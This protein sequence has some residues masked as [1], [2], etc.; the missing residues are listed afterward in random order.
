MNE[1]TRD[2]SLDPITRSFIQEVDGGPQP[3]ELPLDRARQSLLDLQGAAIARPD[4]DTIDWTI[5]AGPTGRVSLRIVRPRGLSGDLPAVMYF[6]GGGWV[7]GDKGTHDRIVRELAARTG[8]AV[9]FVDYDRSPEARYPVA[10]EQAYAATRWVSENGHAVFIDGSRLA[11]AGD[12]SGGNLAAAVALLANG[13][14]KP[15]LAFQLLLFP[16]LDAAM[17]TASYDEY[18]TGPF[19]TRAQMEWFWDSYAPD[20]VVRNGSMVSPLRASTEQLRGLPPTLVIT[21]EHDLLRDE[22]EVYARKLL[23][24]GV[25]ATAVRY[26]NT[27]HSFMVL[28][29]LATSPPARAALTQA[30][31]A[32]RDALGG[33][34]DPPPPHYADPPP[35]EANVDE[36]TPTKGV[37]PLCAS[38][39]VGISA[40]PRG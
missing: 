22:G 24:A 40:P 1:K 27:I 17:N 13:R 6:H 12:S 10:V 3:H 4:A 28:D 39:C 32:L 20:P 2:L 23:E 26:L 38:T 7:L 34:G 11:V 33:T 35:T 5:K 8:A 25:E 21:D 9:V 19:L 16:A 18:E 30:S 31:S 29:A 37:P 14:R 15:K 36:T